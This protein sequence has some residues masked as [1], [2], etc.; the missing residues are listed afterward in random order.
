MEIA[1]TRGKS[2]GRSWFGIQCLSINTLR[3]LSWIGQ[4]WPWDP[5]SRYME[6]KQAE[7]RGSSSPNRMGLLLPAGGSNVL[8]PRSYLWS[9][10]SLPTA[11]FGAP[12][13]S[14]DSGWT[15]HFTFHKHFLHLS[16]QKGPTRREDRTPLQA[17][18]LSRG[19]V[20]N[21]ERPCSLLLT[22]TYG[23]FAQLCVYL[24]HFMW[25]SGI[26]P[27]LWGLTGGEP[28]EAYLARQIL[29]LWP[30]IL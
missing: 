1:L 15:A 19:K 16:Y 2:L 18:Q 8:C 28:A 13:A 14:L 12:R 24:A 6:N 3:S 9:Q 7:G 27:Q 5:V 22:V 4:M 11:K 25:S 30:L 29:N 10:P 17:Q 20:D 23:S 21:Q 26:C